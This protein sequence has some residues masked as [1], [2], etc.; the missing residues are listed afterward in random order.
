ML[1]TT[2]QLLL[3]PLQHLYIICN[4]FTSFTTP[5]QSLQHF[6]NLYNT[7]TTSTT[8][9][10]PLQHHYNMYNTFTTLLQ[11]LRLYNTLTT[12]AIAVHHPCNLPQP[13]GDLGECN[14]Q[15]LRLQ[16]VNTGILQPR[17]NPRLPHK[18]LKY[19]LWGAAEW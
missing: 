13:E 11:P 2:P 6:W 8:P 15:P 19:R 16:G 7:F 18:R 5:L 10:H 1:F 4:I 3:Q 17:H 9:L 14:S 12:S